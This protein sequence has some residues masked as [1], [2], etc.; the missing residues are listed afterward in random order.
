MRTLRT[1]VLATVVLT[2]FCLSGSCKK[3]EVDEKRNDPE[4]EVR[5][6]FSHQGPFLPIDFELHGDTLTVLFSDYKIDE[7]ES[8]IGVFKLVD[9]QW[10]LQHF[11]SEQDIPGGLSFPHT[12][13]LMP[14]GFLISDTENNRAIEIDREGKVIRTYSANNVNE[15]LPI[16]FQGQKAV[17]LSSN[18]ASATILIMNRQRS[19]LWSYVFREHF[20]DK[21][22]RQ[23]HHA[24]RLENGNILVAGTSN[25]GK[26]MEINQKKEVVWQFQHDD[27][28]W[29]R[30]AHRLSNGNTLIAHK[31]GIWEVTR[32]GKITWK[33][34]SEKTVYNLQRLADGTTVAIFD[35]SVI[36]IP[37]NCDSIEC[38]KKW[39]LYRPPQQVFRFDNQPIMPPSVLKK[40]KNHPYLN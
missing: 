27:L 4:P 3:A 13:A 31:H 7:I 5:N 30:N 26:I 22:V 6:T 39:F 33:Y 10:Q 16:V 28:T 9:D 1:I 23:I 35:H 32:Q 18:E 8:G 2:V 34:Q 29:P 17:L 38:V 36:W 20:P 11:I 19:V 24:N 14:D 40:L 21:P 37:K 25:N 15:A 12:L